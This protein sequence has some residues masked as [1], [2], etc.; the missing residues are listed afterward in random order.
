M[1]RGAWLALA[2]IVAALAGLDRILDRPS[3]AAEA[4]ARLAALEEILR[5][6][7]DNDPRLDRDFQGLSPEAKALFREKYRALPPERRNERGTI[8][9]LLGRNLTASEDW[10]FMRAVA[11][12]PPCLSLEDCSKASAG[13][14]APGDGVTLAYPSL[15]ALRQ[16]H[17]AARD[18]A[19][20]LEA[21]RVLEAAKT[22]RMKAVTRLAHALEP[23][24]DTKAP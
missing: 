18:G 2:A 11:A 21:R 4:G 10:A 1:S 5:A 22:S 19:P 20:V 15:V 8:V 23:E 14:G 6:R 9:Y 24:F 13:P 17:R 16:A 3:P 7:D 12:E